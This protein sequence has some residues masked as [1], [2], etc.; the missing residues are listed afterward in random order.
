MN[1]EQ[2]I[3]YLLENFDELTTSDLQ[4][5]IEAR[6]IQTGEDEEVILQAVYKRVG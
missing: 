5:V 3:D 1:K 6:C 2:I 4:G